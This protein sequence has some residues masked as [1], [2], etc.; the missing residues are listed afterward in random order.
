MAHLYH[1][2]IFIQK[3]AALPYKSKAAVY[4]VLYSL[5]ICFVVF[6]PAAGGRK[7]SIR[8]RLIFQS[9]LSYLNGIVRCFLGNI[10]IVRMRF[11][12]TRACYA[13]KL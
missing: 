8:V 9:I 4:C 2:R 13:D 6:S 12:K 10:D 5:T 3:T 11:F 1:S 7:H